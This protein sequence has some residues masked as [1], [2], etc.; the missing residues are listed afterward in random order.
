MYKLD[1]DIKGTDVLVWKTTVMHI[2]DD[3][4]FKI[5]LE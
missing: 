2:I 1:K 3:F 4:L 5:S